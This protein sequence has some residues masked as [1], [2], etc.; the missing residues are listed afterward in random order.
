MASN[1]SLTLLAGANQI[2]GCI[3]HISN[4]DDGCLVDCGSN[5]SLESEFYGG[6]HRPRDSHGLKD[7]LLLGTIPKVHGLLRPDAILDPT[8]LKGGRRLVNSALALTHAHIDHFGLLYAL[9]W[10]IP[11]YCSS[12]SAAFLN[13]V[14]RC[15]RGMASE[16]THLVEREPHPLEIGLIRKPHGGELTAREFHLFEHPRH[17]LRQLWPSRDGLRK[18]DDTIAGMPFEA[19]PVDHSIWGAVSYL[20]QTAEGVAAHLGDTRMHGSE[21]DLTEAAVRRFKQAGTDVL[22][23]EGTQ[24]GR[25]NLGP[26]VTEAQCAKT[27][28]RLVGEAGRRIV[29]VAV[30]PRHLERL[31][32]FIGAAL[33]TGRRLLLPASTIVMLEAVSAANP[34]YD[35]LD[36]GGIGIYDPPQASRREYQK[37]I[38]QR[39]ESLLVHPDEVRKAP[40][41]FIL[42]HTSGP[43][44]NDIEPY[45]GLFIWSSSASY[46]EEA[47]ARC[48]NLRS[49]VAKYRM[50]TEG[51]RFRPGGTDFDGAL[52]PSGHLH[53]DD[54]RRILHT[55]KPRM[56]IP[57]HTNAPEAFF[58]LVPKG[59]EVVIP[60]N[61]RAIRL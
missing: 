8:W 61:G 55:V 28:R 34:R 53:P 51:I 15:G 3:L 46:S 12:T 30:S 50:D 10:D 27:I 54:L 1:T 42:L 20:F 22:V 40:H 41:K 2:G 14:W 36:V 44:L 49:Y 9:N 19:H 16:T 13:S 38:R 25:P 23:A 58:D 45:G 4:K 47:R 21:A 39:Y 18:A 31:A 43:A 37:E 24:L 57:V 11:I 56:V 26:Q 60:R 5:L 29:I 17:E 32:A 33:D 48:N 59:T 52:N 7:P 6:W 35:L